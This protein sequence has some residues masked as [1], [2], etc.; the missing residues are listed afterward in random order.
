VPQADQSAY[1]AAG[2]GKPAEQQQYAGHFAPQDPGVVGGYAPDQNSQP[3]QQAQ[4]GAPVPMA[5]APG[6]STYPNQQLAPGAAG[7]YDPNNPQGSPHT[8]YSQHSQP[9]SPNSASHLSGAYPDRGDA[10]SPVSANRL[11]NAD[12]SIAG[13]VSPALQQQQ[14]YA[15]Y[16]PFQEQPPQHPPQEMQASSAAGPWPTNLHEGT[17]EAPTSETRPA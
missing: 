8:P 4:Y 3:M 6:N 16:A 11:S 2:S 1:A 12:G 14:T 7:V 15:P 10:T 5:E 9:L 17:Y 13:G